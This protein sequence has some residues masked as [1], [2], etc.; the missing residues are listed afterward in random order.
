MLN[1][2]QKKAHTKGVHLKTVKADMCNFTI[3]PVDF[4][5]IMMGTIGLIQSNADLLHL[6]SV[7]KSLK[8]GG[9]YLM[10]NV[11]QNWT[12]KIIF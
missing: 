11:K 5:F 10:E 6:D 9:L 4:T 7:A 1:Y 3:N 12:S 8:K 2:L